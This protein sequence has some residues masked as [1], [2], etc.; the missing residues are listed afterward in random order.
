[1]QI[2]DP[3][4]IEQW[5]TQLDI[6]F[7]FAIVFFLMGGPVLYVMY[8]KALD[9]YLSI[10]LGVSVGLLIM[11]AGN[12]GLNFYLRQLLPLAV[13][14]LAIGILSFLASS[15]LSF[16]VARGVEFWARDPGKPQWVIEMENIPEEEMSILDQKRKAYQES[17]KSRQ[18]RNI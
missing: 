2:L 9:D 4:F 16:L 18:N 3:A 10:Y 17:R 8:A 13:T 5:Q 14:D 15:S 12:F 6:G 1:M 11:V 7:Q